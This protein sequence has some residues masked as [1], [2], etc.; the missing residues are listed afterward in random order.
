MT[1]SDL[2]T[3]LEIKATLRLCVDLVD[4]AIGCGY[5]PT[6]EGFLKTVTEEKILKQDGGILATI[7][8]LTSWW[9]REA[10]EQEA[11]QSRYNEQMHEQIKKEL[12]ALQVIEDDLRGRRNR[13]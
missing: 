4:A 1:H 12:D 13:E 2:T 3:L 10:E 7:V 5:R 11:A 6:A 9:K 8:E